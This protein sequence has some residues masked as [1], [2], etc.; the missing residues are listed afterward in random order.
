MLGIDASCPGGSLMGGDFE[1]VWAGLPENVDHPYRVAI[2]E[3]LW[4]TGEPLS[5]IGVVDVLDGYMSM[6]NA[7]AHL[8]ALEQLG[9]IEPLSGDRAAH[10]RED[11]FDVRYR[12]VGPEVGVH[13]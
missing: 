2:I 3:A 8:K 9:V 11:R 10:V 12:L 1:S 13:G 4:R 5:A 6:W 7:A